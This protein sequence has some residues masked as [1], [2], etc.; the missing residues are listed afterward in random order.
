MKRIISWFAEN[1]VAA[2]LLMVLIIAGG[3]VTIGAIP[4][5]PSPVKREVFPELESNLITVAVEYLGA[6]PEEVEE[7]I[8]VRVEEAIQGLEGIKEITSSAAEGRGSVTVEVEADFDTREL[9][10]DIKNR[11]D[12]IDTFPEETEKPIVQEVLIRRQVMDVVVHGPADERTLKTL[13]ERVRDEIAALPGISQ[14]ELVNARPYEIS[15]EISEEDLRRHGLTFDQVVAAIRRSSLD[16][17][18]GSIK[19]EGGEI[20]LRSKGQAYRGPEFERIVLITRPDGTYLRIGDV[21]TVVDGFAETDQWTRFDGQGSVS[22]RVFRVGDQSALDIAAKVEEYVAT[23]EGRMPE[24]IKLTIWS[25]LSRILRS[26]MDL[27]LRNGRTGIFL[28]FMTLALFLRFRLAFWVT[29]GM[30]ISFLGTLWLLPVLGV[31][32]S[33]ISLFAFIAVL[34]I[35]VDDAIVV[36]ESIYTEQSRV[37]RSVKASIAGAHRVYTPVIFAVL[38][39][40][41]AF[42]PMLFVEGTMGR[43]MRVIPLIVIPTLLFSLVESMLIL[44]SHLS[45]A[46]RRK[47]G[48]HGT[49]GWWGRLQ[50]KI[51]SGLEAFIQ[52]TYRNGLARALKW[53]YLTVAVGVAF[54]LL[55]AGMAGGGWIKFTFFPPVEADNV[56]AVVT[57]PLGTPAEVTSRAVERIERV[58]VELLRELDERHAQEG[59]S[60]YRHMM[61]SVG[62]Q[63]FR[64]RQSQGAGN[65]GISFVGAHMGEVNLELAPAEE[66]SVKGGEIARLWRERV[67]AIPDALELTFSSSLFDTGEPINVQFT[68]P[69]LAKLREAADRLK[70]QLTTYPGVF[71][72]ADSFRQGKQEVKL[73]IKPSAETL[74]LTLADLARQ[75][76]QGF[77]GEE[78]QRMQRGRD[79]IRVMVRYPEEERRSLGD[80]ENMRIR[81]REGS[82]VPFAAVADADLG[83]GYDTIVRKERRR[84]VSVTADVDLSVANANEI[85]ADLDASFLPDL[86]ADYPA[87]LYTFEGQQR[88]QRETLGGLWRG[89]A[90]ALLVI[91][92]MLAIPLRSYIQP[93]VIMSAI[94]FGLVGA[95]LGH[96]IMGMDLTILSMFGI[97]ALAGV[98]V[99]DSLVLVDYVNRLRAEGRSVLEAAREGGVFRFRAILLTSLTTFAGLSPLMMERSLQAQFLIPMAISLAFGVLFSTGITLGLVPAGY[100]ILDDLQQFTGRLLGRAPAADDGPALGRARAEVAAI[101]GARGDAAAGEEPPEAAAPSENP[102]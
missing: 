14:T 73:A 98:V 97:V 78:A 54:L 96:V 43:V 10:D 20:L 31:S 66:R 25:D 34:G 26:R 21:A 59:G 30:F 36:G 11:I 24:G 17:P 83:R 76:R 4:G 8:C 12:A 87:M 94:P 102:T 39:S 19:T 29:V 77:Y 47:P 101:E 16:L 52:R 42:M 60:I 37:G 70:E 88:E 57:M 81:T 68:G 41:V 90:I 15:I 9:L 74:G 33:L 89:F 3:L 62:D 84:T 35:V 32:I 100:V 46:R 44:P 7:A 72:I 91:F 71:D 92:A 45:H 82:E 49:F 93:L 13:G 48:E 56:A 18:G 2:N 58:G 95:L 1:S 53:R 69:D 55:A 28:V 22:V 63:P 64:T 5:I 99:N 75:V 51:S 80:L 40:V 79:D 86:L 65:V 85:L 38:T 27:L 67:G 50:G 23:A 6:A 61:A